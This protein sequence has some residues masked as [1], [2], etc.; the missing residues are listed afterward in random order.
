[1]DKLGDNVQ[2]Q[3]GNAII[4]ASVAIYE[5]GTTTLVAI[6]EDDETTPKVNPMT[7]DGA[8]R[9]ECKIPAGT[10]DIAIA[11]AGEVNL[12][13]G[14]ST[15]SVGPTS[16]TIPVDDSSFDRL[17]TTG[18]DTVQ[19]AFDAIDDRSVIGAANL[20]TPGSV[21]LVDGAGSVTE[22]PV[23][24]TDFVEG[25][26]SATDNAL[27]RYDGVTGKLVQDGPVLVDDDG[28]MT[29]VDAVTFNTTLSGSAPSAAGAMNYNSSFGCLEYNTGIPGVS[30][31]VGQEDHDPY[32]WD[33][34]GTLLNLKP[35][36][37]MG[38]FVG[39][40]ETVGLA[41]TSATGA[42]IQ[43]RDVA[44]ITTHDA[45][46]DTDILITSRGL[47][48]GDTSAWPVGTELWVGNEVLTA[49]RPLLPASQW[50]VGKVTVQ[51]AVNG[52]LQVNL[53]DLSWTGPIIAGNQSNERT[54]F[55]LENGMPIDTAG[56]A[57][58]LDGD[59]PTRTF[60]I[61]SAAGSFQFF[62]VSNLFT[63]V[64]DQSVVWTDVEGDHFFY[65][66]EIG[67][68]THTTVFDESFILGPDVFVAYIYWDA[69]NKRRVLGNALTET[70]GMQM[71]GASH[72]QFH[73]ALGAQWVSGLV[74]DSLVT[75]GNGSANTDAQFGVE[76]GVIS[77]EDL[78]YPISAVAS[79]VGLPIVYLEGAT[80]LTRETSNAGFS[81]ITDTQF[82]GITTTDRLVYNQW[83]GTEWVVT[84]ASSTDFVLGHVLAIGMSEYGGT[85]ERL[86]AAM[87][88][89]TY[90][91]SSAARDG[92]DTEMATLISTLPFAEIRPIA[93]VIFQTGNY[94][95]DV[96]ARCRPSELGVNPSYVDWRKDNV[97]GGGS[98]TPSTHNDLSGR[99]DPGTHP[100][101]EAPP[102]T[103]QVI[104]MADAAGAYKVSFTDS[105]GVEVAYIDSN[106][107]SSFGGSSAWADLTGSINDA[108][109][110]ANGDL[111]DLVVG[112]TTTGFEPFQVAG[113]ARIEGTGVTYFAWKD[114]T[115][116][117]QWQWL[118]TDTDGSFILSELGGTGNAIQ[119]KPSD[120]DDTIYLL[121]DTVVGPTDPTG[122]ERLRVDGGVRTTDNMTIDA[123][124]AAANGL[125][126]A[127]NDDRI[128]HFGI[129]GDSSDVFAIVDETAGAFR[130]QIDAAGAT[131][132]GTG[133]TSSGTYLSVASRGPR[134]G[135]DASGDTLASFPSGSNRWTFSDSAG[136]GA[137]AYDAT[138]VA[139]Q[140]RFLIYDV[141]N[142]TLERVTVGAADSGGSGYK[143]LRIP[144]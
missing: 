138:A 40:R 64:G 11:Y 80:A 4:G 32:H 24:L 106:G 17:L 25:P 61:G 144:N 102:G 94:A 57:V 14:F 126:Y 53:K 56:T 123:A 101:L 82:G 15:P 74:L 6:Y 132:L 60:T 49:T 83:T 122:S 28:Q 23:I 128:W 20:V 39:G 30:N 133:I 110:F 111:S 134:F 113:D 45:T 7:S 37:L 115:T 78:R 72:L 117:T 88:Q 76:S 44:G 90:G 51:D 36:Y 77:D 50:R 29:G 5:E 97:T 42:D 35:V 10:Y 12:W 38:S 143:V 55:V 131:V 43:K 127:Q 31:Q 116:D 68:L 66:N 79:T 85:G 107:G 137:I 46:T 34:A 84:A 1:M 71:S 136:T 63:K 121:K 47:I 52:K 2:D 108:A 112:G 98:F 99:N 124:G 125:Y 67:V 13:S 62:S 69:T 59:D 139:G 3:Y 22:S 19:K 18:D 109:S 26:A 16:S 9:W 33:Q 21:V 86:Y 75:D 95:N 130:L 8:G 104:K 140:T 41:N 73:D 119:V 120:G 100:T 141:D 65:F 27:P 81:V 135:I 129:R 105:A 114:T 118:V 93:S 58:H 103:D 89:A 54:G 87:G 96:S 70:H 92:A 142:G 91:S 48:T